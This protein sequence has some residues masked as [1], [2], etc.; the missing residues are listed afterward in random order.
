MTFLPD[1]LIDNHGVP[2]HEWEQQFSGYTSPAYKGFWLPRSLLYGYFYHITGEAYRSNYV[3]NKKMEDVI[4]DA[5]MDDE[6]ITR[7]NKM[8]AEQFEKYAH[9]WLPKMFP[10]DYYKNMINYW[11]PHEYDPTHRYPSIRYPWILSLDY[12]SEVADETAQGD[13]LYSCAR[14]HMVHDVAILEKIMQASCVYKQE[15][16]MQE[17]YIKAALTRK[18]PIII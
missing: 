15:W 11:I 9:A 13:Y 7:E 4:A 17:D 10:A 8:W 16:E 6:E 14:A 18:R 3:L 1:V 2:S 12:V 5:F